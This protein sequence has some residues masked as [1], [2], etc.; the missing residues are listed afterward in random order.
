MDD[1]QKH[2]DGLGSSL[3]TVLATHQE[4]SVLAPHPHTKP[5]VA[6]CTGEM[7]T[8]LPRGL[9]GELQVRGG[10]GDSV[11]GGRQ[12]MVN[13][14]LYMHVHTPIHIAHQTIRP[15]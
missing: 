12:S 7:E 15:F 6:A 3:S 1:L 9:M 13:S 2:D 4:N 14:G 10:G 11:N 8:G 5:D